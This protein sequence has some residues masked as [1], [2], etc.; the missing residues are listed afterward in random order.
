MRSVEVAPAGHVVT[1]S[2][3]TRSLEQNALLW[4]LLEEVSRQVEWYGKKLSPESWK[5]VFSASIRKLDVVP[6]L[7]G[8]GFVT[9]GQSTSQMSKRE[10]SD[11]IETIYAF[12]AQRGVEFKEPATA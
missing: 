4:P 2:E 10:F 9:L 8:T 3:P 7:E 1:I 12:G 6:N 5:H 11:L